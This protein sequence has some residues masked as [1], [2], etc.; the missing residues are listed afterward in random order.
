MIKCDITCN[1]GYQE[2]CDSKS[3][4]GRASKRALHL[5]GWFPFYVHFQGIN[6]TRY[7][8]I[9]RQ[10]TGISRSRNWVTKTNVDH[11]L[12]AYK[13]QNKTWSWIC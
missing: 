10:W 6:A 11:W 13:A 12:W 1:Q 3:C 9:R 7:Q 4:T 8:L 2:L 5:F